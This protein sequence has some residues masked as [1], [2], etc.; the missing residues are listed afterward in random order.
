M[1]EP[2]G[3]DAT[4]DPRTGRPII[5]LDA[6]KRKDPY[7]DA[8]SEPLG[9]EDNQDI[10]MGE[11]EDLMSMSEEAD[12][13]RA[14]ASEGDGTQA[15]SSVP[16]RHRPSVFLRTPLGTASTLIARV[17]RSERLCRCRLRRGSVSGVRLGRRRRGSWI[18]GLGPTPCCRRWGRGGRPRRCCW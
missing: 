14:D 13:P 5:P 9:D 15:P 10:A 17:S 7:A 1:T 11:D 3:Y 4:R 12:G 16:R 8:V 6:E 2:K 18:G